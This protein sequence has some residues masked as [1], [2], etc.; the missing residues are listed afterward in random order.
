MNTGLRPLLINVTTGD[1]RRIGEPQC[2]IGYGY[3]GEEGLITYRV[4]HWTCLRLRASFESCA[5]LAVW[6]GAGVRWDEAFEHVF[7]HV[8]EVESDQLAGSWR[9]RLRGEGMMR[10]IEESGLGIG[11]SRSVGLR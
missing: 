2:R 11:N 6:R 10:G 8:F 5:C 1:G 9:R 3:A 4:P 7:E